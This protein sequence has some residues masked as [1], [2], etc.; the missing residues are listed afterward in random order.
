MTVDNVAAK[1]QVMETIRQ[2][3]KTIK[4]LVK[5]PGRLRTWWKSFIQKTN[6]VAINFVLTAAGMILTDPVIL[7]IVSLIMLWRYLHELF[8]VAPQY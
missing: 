2:T 3:A 7:I 1:F 6:K 8:D 4:L 5:L